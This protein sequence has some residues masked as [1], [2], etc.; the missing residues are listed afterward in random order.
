MIGDL[1]YV[2]GALVI[3]FFMM[4]CFVGNSWYNTGKGF[5]FWKIFGGEKSAVYY[6]AFTLAAMLGI[7]SPYI[8]RIFTQ[9]TN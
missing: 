9:Y 7:I 8:I 1:I 3:I 4:L 5:S 6:A 2:A